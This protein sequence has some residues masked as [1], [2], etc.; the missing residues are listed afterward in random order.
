M[1]TLLDVYKEFNDYGLILSEPFSCVIDEEFITQSKMLGLNIL[2]A[3]SSK[4]Q[5]EDMRIVFES[6]ESENVF[7]VYL[8]DSNNIAL[9]YSRSRIAAQ[10]IMENLELISQRNDFD[11]SEKFSY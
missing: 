6:N 1:K 10:V 11:F 3:V 2:E 7:C 8:T 5:E 4:G 9:F